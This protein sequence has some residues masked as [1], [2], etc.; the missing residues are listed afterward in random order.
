LTFTPAAGPGS[1]CATAGTVTL[2]SSYT[3]DYPSLGGSH[4]WTFSAAASTTYYVKVTVNSGGSGSCNVSKGT[5]ALPTLLFTI[6]GSGCNTLNES[7]A[8]TVLIQI[9]GPV[10]GTGNYT[11]KCDTGSC[12]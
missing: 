11:L 6:M 1:T 10:L 2:G 9:T 3:Y 5:C 12:P 4:W 8:V 7:S